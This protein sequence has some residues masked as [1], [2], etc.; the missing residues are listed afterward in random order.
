MKEGPCEWIASGGMEGE[1]S[2]KKPGTKSHRTIRA[3][4]KNLDFILHAVGRFYAPIWLTVR[5]KF[6]CL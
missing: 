6:S 3:A 4:A 1:E 2:E 5:I